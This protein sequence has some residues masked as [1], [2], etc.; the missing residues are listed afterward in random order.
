[1]TAIYQASTGISPYFKL[2]L[3]TSVSDVNC[4][5]TNDRLVQASSP[6]PAQTISKPVP[7]NGGP[8]CPGPPTTQ[9]LTDGPYINYFYSDCNVQTQ[10]VVTSPLSDSN[11]SIIG[12]RLIVA[13]PA[14]NSGVCAFF[15]PQNGVNGSL[16]IELVNS[17]AGGALAPVYVPATG[18]SQYPRVGVSGTVRFNS[19]ATLT[20]PILGSIRTI[21]D[22]TE[23][24]SL[25]YPQI[26]KALMFN[27]TSN[28]GVT[29]SRLWLD[30]VTVTDLAFIPQMASGAGKVTIGNQTINLTAGDYTFY[31]DF[32]YPQLTQLNSST[33]L[34]SASQALITQQPDQTK[35]LQFLSY[36]EKLL[37]G[38][39]RF[40]TYFGRDSMIAALLLQPVLSD[41]AVEAVI[42]AVLER[43]NRT[44]GSACHEETIGDYA[45]YL[46]EKMNITSTAP[47]YDYKMIDTDYYLPVLMDRYFLSSGSNKTNKATKILNT[48]AGT[49]DPA[50][51]G[52]T[53]AQLALINAEKIMAIAG[54]YAASGNQTIANLAHLK[55]DQIVGEWRDSTYGI[56][57]G[58]IPFDVNTGLM[59][60]ALRSISALSAAGIYANHTTDWPTLAATYAQTWEDTTLSFFAVTIP[61]ST[62][63]S[64]LTTYVQRSSFPGPAQTNLIDS[65]VHFNAI[66]L[67]GNNNLS[68]VQVMHTDTCFRLFLLNTTNQPQLTSFLNNT[69]TNVQ[70]TFPAGLLTDV[71]MLV[72]NPAFGEQAVYAENFTTSAYHGTVVWSWQM[73][74][75][76]RGLEL[77]LSRCTSASAPDF[78]KDAAVYNNVK[79]GY[80]ALW[81]V[82]EANSVHLST[83]VWSWVFENGEFVFTEL[84]T[85][86]PPPGTSPTESDIRQLWSLT[87]LA[88]KRAGGLM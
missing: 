51:K 60:A 6:A 62:A 64:R 12:P 10:A 3:F 49:V 68:Q 9:Y 70:R 33:V 29:I 76:A 45:T 23:G 37:A 81:D 7:G 8:T 30:N 50:N 78:C 4:S 2:R 84:G 43:I 52:L 41:Q 66:A 32:N 54:Q 17:T 46:N 36:S 16:G 58:R 67:D 73:A 42:G 38:A 31:A 34:N 39:W 20:V 65:D 53:Y 74:M 11:L 28:G 14:G 77:Q 15:A 61:A 40:L 86:P 13:W 35:S 80:N 47:M 63:Q 1:M 55:A 24:P 19:S 72:A 87:F 85:L 71:G 21:R 25:L 56:G 57:G 83:E 26:Q 44:D 79:K 75:M 48:M 88:V 82:I 59:P 5:C 22:F 27:S 18:S 69:A